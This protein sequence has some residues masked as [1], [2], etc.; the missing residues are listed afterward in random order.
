[1]PT[2]TQFDHAATPMYNAFTTTPDF[3]PIDCVEPQIDLMTR[4][5]DKGP[6]AQASLKLDFSDYD[7]A[8]PDE[9]NRILWTALKPGVPMP[10]PVRSGHF[11]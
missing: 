5:P 4:N 6:G 1:L 8:D 10:A 2:M 9:L 3:T 7:R 11:R